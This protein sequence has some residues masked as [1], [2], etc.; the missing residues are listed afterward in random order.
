MVIFL[1]AGASAADG[2]PVQSALFRE[3]FQSTVIQGRVDTEMKT[4]LEQY[5][6]QLWGID[7]RDDLAGVNFPTFEEALG[8]LDIADSRRETFRNMGDDLHGTATQEIR[9]HLTALIALILQEKLNGNHNNHRDL[10]SA[11]RASDSLG[12]T[13]FISLNYDDIIDNA[14]END[15]IKHSEQRLADYGVCF[16]PRPHINNRPFGKASLLLKLH[17][18]LNWRYCSACNALSLFQHQKALTELPGAPWHFRCQKCNTL[19]T[20]IIIPPTFFK[21]MSNFYLQQIWKRAEEELKQARRIIFCGYSFPDADIHIKYLLKRAEVN[22]TG[23]PPQVFIVN[24][25]EDKT[26]EECDVENDR[27]RRFFRR[28]DQVHWTNLSFERFAANPQE[29]E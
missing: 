29:I 14:I 8:I 20:A 22:R 3:Y 19:R 17:G 6:L 7:V 2:A 25:H 5:F 28:K 1:G 4:A 13:V 12:Q 10:L 24:E 23:H 15:S 11:L 18:S 16:S 27:Y 21:V 9:N 26:K